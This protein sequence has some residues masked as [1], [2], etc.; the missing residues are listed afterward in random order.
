MADFSVLWAPHRVLP[1]VQSI[2]MKRFNIAVT[3]WSLVID[4]TTIFMGLVLAYRLR[5]GGGELYAWP[6]ITYLRLVAILLPVWLFFFAVQ[7][8]YDI[9]NTPRG[10]SAFSKLLIGLLGGWG[11]LIITFYLWRSTAAENFPRLVMVYG[12][13]LTAGLTLFGRVLVSGVVQAL[14]LRGIGLTRCIVVT[15]EKDGAFVT[16]LKQQENRGRQL[17]LTVEPKDATN[18]AKLSQPQPDEIIVASNGV[19]DESLIRLLDWAE[20]KNINL[21]VVPSLLSIRSAN[22]ESGSL[23]GRQVTFFR[24]SPLEGWGRVFKRVLDLLIVIPTLI[25]MSPLYLVLA[26]AVVLG[27]RGP[28]MYREPRVGQDG[29]SLFIRKFRSMYVDWRDRFPHVKDWSSDESTDPRITPIGRFIRKTNLDELPQLWDVLLGKM[30]IV[31][32]RPEQPKYVE[33]FS[34]EIP[35]YLKRHRVKSGL[36][37]W[38]QINGLRGNTPVS[39]RVKYDIYYIENWSIWFDLRIIIGTFV[40]IFRRLAKS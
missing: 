9:R 15:N 39:D 40:Y 34:Q 22:V 20:S 32:P 2:R 14:Y 29:R 37:G 1:G 6:F 23:A 11:I 17:V 18:F 26:L 31:G 30:S 12:M 7:G 25:I 5:S 4:I 35:D 36:T 21:V 27:S 16:K 3:L 10:W 19:S 28:I 33:K 24:R 13:L 38:A 8:L